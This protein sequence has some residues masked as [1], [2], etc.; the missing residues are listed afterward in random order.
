MRNHVRK[1]AVES[2]TGITNGMI[3]V[4]PYEMNKKTPCTFCSYKPVCQF[5]QTLEE[6]QFRQLRTEKDEFVL[7]KMMQ[8]G[9]DSV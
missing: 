5:D 3:D 8:E 4:A 7:E 1:K 9:G 2:G 6:N